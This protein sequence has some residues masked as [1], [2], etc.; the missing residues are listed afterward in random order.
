VAASLI[1]G[2]GRAF[3][4]VFDRHRVRVHRHSL[5]L[6]ARPVDAEDVLAVTFFEAWRH[7]ERI[8]FV[9]GSLL[10]W[11]LVTAT[12]T[13]RNVTRSTKRYQRLLAHLPPPNPVADPADSVDGGVVSETLARLRLVDQQILTL[14]VI[15]DLSVR[16]AA[17]ALGVSPGTVKSRLHRAKSRM[18]EHINRPGELFIEGAS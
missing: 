18:R 7:R 5:G 15:L 2:D 13:A 10:P 1:D 16:D 4:A 9:D 6:V 8:R 17:L 11:P 14:C 12:N 3:T